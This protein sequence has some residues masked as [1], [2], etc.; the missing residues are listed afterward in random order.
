M[1]SFMLIVFARLRCFQ[2]KALSETPISIHLSDS[3]LSSRDALKPQLTL[4]PIRQV[5]VHK[6]LEH[7]AVIWRKQMNEFVNDDEFTNVPRQSQQLRV[8]RQTT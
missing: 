2:W 6:T 4:F 3:H 8:E 7:L 1:R 5:R